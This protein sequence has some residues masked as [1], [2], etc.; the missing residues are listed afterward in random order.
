MRKLGKTIWAA[1]IGASITGAL[2]IVAV[3]LT[4]YL[5]PTPPTLPPSIIEQKITK[6]SQAEAKKAMQVVRK[7]VNLPYS[8]LQD[9]QVAKFDF[10]GDGSQSETY[11]IA[12]DHT[13]VDPISSGRYYGIYTERTGARNCFCTKRPIYLAPLDSHLS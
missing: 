12:T 1:I 8:S 6:L 3:L 4:V 2:G 9:A 10:V 5:R 13:A 7:L 11:F